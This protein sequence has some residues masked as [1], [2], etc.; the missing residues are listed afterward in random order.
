MANLRALESP[1][2]PASVS[3]PAFRIADPWLIGGLVFAVLMAREL[4][5]GPLAFTWEDPYFWANTTLF[6]PWGGHVQLA[7]RLAFAIARLTPSIGPV[8]TTVLHVLVVAFVAAF[9]AS[10][11]LAP[12]IPDRRLRLVLAGSLAIIPL[13]SV[14]LSPINA[15][16]FLAL[17]LVGLS[18]T[19][20]I[21]KVDYIG[22]ALA[23]LSGIGAAIALPL[24]WRDRR[25]LVL[26]GCTVFQAAVL[27]A[28][29][30]EP[31]GLAISIEFAALSILVIVALL[32]SDL[33][34]R[35]RFSFG[36][37][38]IA[39]VVV[40]SYAI[41]GA[42]GGARYILAAAVCLILAASGAALQGRA[43]GLVILGVVVA[44][45]LLAFPI[46]HVPG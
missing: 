34:A 31:G 29:N 6:D 42:T 43:H 3:S 35:T 33:P 21:R 10:S 5:G 16:W 30:R 20:E 18:L 45:A 27:L 46:V 12:A 41:G 8:V 24:F 25:G 13:P 40:G 23:G 32:L 17:Y 1:W 28:S 19:T 9:L 44:A 39:T 14:Y 2:R 36:Y 26:F 15:Q 38:G 22:V 37:M 11:R 4:A 7:S